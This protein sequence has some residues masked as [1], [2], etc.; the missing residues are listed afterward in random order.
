VLTEASITVRYLDEMLGGTNNADLLAER[1][2]QR[3]LVEVKSASGA[4]GERLV[5]APARHLATWPRLRPDLPVEGVV[6][7]LNHQTNTHPLDRDPAPYRRP[8][9]VSS[10]QMPIFTTRQLFDWWRSGEH[11]AIRAAIFGRHAN[12]TPSDEASA[13]ALGGRGRRWF[14]RR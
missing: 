7:V 10:L 5:E 13:N 11:E 14:G 8:E 12:A 6:L 2:G 9:F 1:A 4:P 3:V